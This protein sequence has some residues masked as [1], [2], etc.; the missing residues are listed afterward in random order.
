MAGSVISSPPR[1]EKQWDAR[2][3]EPTDTQD[4]LCLSTC[5][6]ARG[7]SA[8]QTWLLSLMPLIQTTA[9]LLHK[10]PA[11]PSLPRIL[12]QT[13]TPPPKPFRQD[14]SPAPASCPPHAGLHPESQTRSIPSDCPAH[15]LPSGPSALSLRLRRALGL[16]GGR[17][18]GRAH[19]RIILWFPT[20]SL[21][22]QHPPTPACLIACGLRTNP[23]AVTMGLSTHQSL[24]F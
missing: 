3:R 6:R 24:S 11:C 15:A 7:R 20:L 1:K 21:L 5:T 4:I 18:A 10:L 17:P 23:L 14:V 12:F 22:R 19:P 9:S 13:T 16:H 8:P 2:R